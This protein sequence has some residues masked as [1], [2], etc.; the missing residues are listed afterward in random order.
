MKPAW[1]ALLA[2]ATLAPVA[3]AQN[4]VVN[5][6]FETGNFAGWVQSG[7]VVQGSG[8]APTGATAPEGSFLY[9]TGA[10]S[11]A[12]FGPA[13]LTQVIATTPGQTYNLSFIAGRIGSEILNNFQVSFGGVNLFNQAIGSVAGGVGPDY[14]RVTLTSAPVTGT[15]TALAFRISNDVGYTL[16]D[17]VRVTATPE[18]ASSV[19]LVSGL[20][21]L[22]AYSRKRRSYAIRGV[23]RCVTDL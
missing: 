10:P 5:G 15:S 2:L 14:R 16:L 17:D 21:G 7:G 23:G 19:L 1:L 4:L 11:F 13:T 12:P 22:I 20:V 3:R 6:G 18:P 8:A 9:A